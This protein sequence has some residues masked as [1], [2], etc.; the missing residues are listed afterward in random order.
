M[1]QRRRSIISVGGPRLPYDAEIEYLEST[2]TQFIDTGLTPGDIGSRFIYRTEIQWKTAAHRQLMGAQDINFFGVD[3]SMRY[4]SYSTMT[5]TGSTS[6]FDIVEFVMA[7]LNRKT[8][9]RF[10]YINETLSSAAWESNTLFSTNRI[11]IFGIYTL[12]G[13]AINSNFLCLCKIKSFKIYNDQTGDV[14]F[15]GIPVRVGTIGYMY[16]RVSGQLFGNAGTGAFIV[17]PDKS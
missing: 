14:Y 11:V 13:T 6:S 8:Y 5:R 12:A 2:G 15:D 10:S 17:G 1:L 4:E 16:D 9:R 7:Y 3:T